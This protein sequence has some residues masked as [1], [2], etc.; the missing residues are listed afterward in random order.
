MLAAVVILAC[1][2]AAAVFR[3]WLLEHDLADQR[4]VLKLLEHDLAELTS[5]LKPDCS[6]DDDRPVHG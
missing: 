6:D 1:A 4:L 5:A 3:I 2:L